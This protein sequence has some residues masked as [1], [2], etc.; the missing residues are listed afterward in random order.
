MK[1]QICEQITERIETLL[2]TGVVPWHKPWKA[3]IG[4]PRNL[5]TNQPYRGINVF[6]L[7]SM[8]DESPSMS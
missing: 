8:S 6:L 2:A 7:R 5:V 4:L 1:A 3:S